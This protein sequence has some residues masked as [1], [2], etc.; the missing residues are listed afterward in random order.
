MSCLYFETE[1]MFVFKEYK[2]RGEGGTEGKGN[3]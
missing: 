1:G 3:L 2:R